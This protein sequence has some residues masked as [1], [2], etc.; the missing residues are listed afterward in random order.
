MKRPVP[1]ECMSKGETRR[2]PM[3]VFTGFRFQTGTCSMES[4]MLSQ[5]CDL[6]IVVELL[7]SV[8]LVEH[9]LLLRPKGQTTKRPLGMTNKHVNPS[10]PQVSTPSRKIGRYT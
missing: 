7:L 5:V 9:H 2:K 3:A 8:L 1:M 4:V 6:Y 10:I